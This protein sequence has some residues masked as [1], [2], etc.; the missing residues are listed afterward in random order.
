MGND[1]KTIRQLFEAYDAQPSFYALIDVGGTQERYVAL[2]S[3]LFHDGSDYTAIFGDAVGF[4]AI[5]EYI[6]QDIE[7]S[8]AV[9]TLDGLQFDSSLLNKTVEVYIGSTGL[10]TSEHLQL[11]EGVVLSE[12]RTS[13]RFTV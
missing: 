12:N 6:S 3:L 8:S 10:D 9:L 7:A 13:Y 2:S 5:S 11:F 1:V 4:S